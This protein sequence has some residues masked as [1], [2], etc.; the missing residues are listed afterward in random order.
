MRI[1]PVSKNRRIVPLVIAAM[2][3]GV[4]GISQLG[5]AGCLPDMRLPESS[6]TARGATGASLSMKL[7]PSH[8]SLPRNPLMIWLPLDTPCM[9]PCTHSCN[10]FQDPSLKFL[11]WLNQESISAMKKMWS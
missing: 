11:L 10:Q 8:Q 7:S 3:A 9:G 2:T 6:P 4:L 1:I 5:R